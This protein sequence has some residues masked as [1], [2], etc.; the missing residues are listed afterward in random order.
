MRDVFSVVL[1]F[2]GV[3]AP[4]GVQVYDASL[5]TVMGR[6]TAYSI[7][8]IANTFVLL[9]WARY[10]Q[11]RFGRRNR[12]RRS[13]PATPSEIGK[14]YALTPDQVAACQSAKR[15]IMVHDERGHLVAFGPFVK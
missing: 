8:I 13:D 7:V 6:L 5:S 2:F 9:A 3:P 4:W 10:N 12:R 11:L 14:F 1:S 15:N